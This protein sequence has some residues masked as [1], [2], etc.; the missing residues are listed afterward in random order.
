MDPL[1]LFEQVFWYLGTIG[2][3]LVAV[4]MMAVRLVGHYPLFFAF[5]VVS[6]V[7]TAILLGHHPGYSPYVNRWIISE[8]LLWVMYILVVYEIQRRVLKDFPGVESLGRWILTGAL[9][10]AV[11]VSSLT[12][13]PDLQSNVKD[14]PVLQLVNVVRRGIAT[15][16]MTFL[17][18]VS[19]FL[20][21]FP[22]PL[23]RNLVVHSL[24]F[25]FWFLSITFSLFVR[26]VFG[27]DLIETVSTVLMGAHCLCLYLWLFLVTRK[28][29]EVKMVFRHNVPPEQEAELLN[30]LTALNRTLAGSTRK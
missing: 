20:V 1:G 5:L 24:V 22:V 11:S 19:G 15:I 10:L 27:P 2:T 13:W 28:G 21:W 3:I 26:N 12:L 8:P 29:E 14:F 16:L 7:R 18:L 17:L 6:T 9:V 4:R 30:H 25:T 23:P